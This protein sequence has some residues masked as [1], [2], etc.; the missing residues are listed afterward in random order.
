MKSFLHVIFISV[1]FS[2]M[3]G[4][5]QSL[6]EAIGI[7]LASNPDMASVK[8]Q[9]RE[10]RLDAKSTY[11]S[12]LPQFDFDASY[13]HVTDRAE[14]NL[15]IG[16]PFPA[17]QIHLGVFDTYETG[18]TANYVLFSGFA[19]KNLVQL[20]NQT[21]KLNNQQMEKTG[22]K[23]A[24]DVIVKYR[25]VQ[26]HMLEI[27]ALNDQGMAL[28]LDTLSLS[29]SRLNNEQKI[30][31]AKAKLENANQELAVL[32]GENIRVDQHTG[33][34]IDKTAAQFN[35][36]NAA[37]LK[38]LVTRMEMMNSGKAVTRAE[39]YPKIGLFAGIK[40]AK[41]GVDFISN[42]WMT[43]G[44]W[45]VNLSWNLFKWGADHI[46]IQS[47]EAA[48]RSTGFQRQVVNDQLKTKFDAAVREYEAL[49]KQYKVAGKARDVAKMKMQIVESR[50]NQGMS[51]VTD[52]NEANLELTD[53]EINLQRQKILLALK[54]S[55]I[56]F[57]SGK[58]I[59]EWRI[60][61]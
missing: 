13:R 10:A 15:Q 34:V 57:L 22:K 51:S 24:L 40:Y 11:R 58:S 60:E 54:I 42:E 7:A 29:L 43:Y 1:L 35:P 49:Q 59:N 4:Y 41:P 18:L 21:V 26:N 9:V 36:D 37:D 23:I 30:I 55:E 32:A 39:Y 38:M 14:L 33:T 27:E 48:I 44:V 53:A 20:K 5:S 8:E 46:K 17:R 25:E 2:F 61:E 56:D 28:P 31:A 45:G 52:F 50:Y 12:T 6:K 47:Q 3:A 19:Q 16:G